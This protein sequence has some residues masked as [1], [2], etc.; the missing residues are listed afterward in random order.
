MRQLLLVRPEPG[1]SASAA[2]ARQAGLDVIACPLFRIEPLEWKL[3]R[4]NDYDGLLLTSA[5]A[6]RCGGSKLSGLKSLPVYAVGAVTADAARAAGLKVE[7][8]GEGDLT[9]LLAK[10]PV[11]IRLLHLA[12]DEHR[13]ADTGHEIDR[14]II[15]RSGPIGQP[16]L[17]PIDGLVVAVHSPRAGARLAELEDQRDRTAIAAISVAAANATGGGWERIEVAE[18]PNDSSLLALAA[19]LCHT[20]PPK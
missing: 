19:S 2:R 3:P 1:L 11:E 18:R 10:L 16:G 7:M 4:L 12:G 14:R 13:E 8:V 17:P 5:N 9:D 6:P 20:S 15:Y